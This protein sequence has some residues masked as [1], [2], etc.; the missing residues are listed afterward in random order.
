MQ[1]ARQFNLPAAYDAH[2]LALAERLEAELWTL[3]RKLFNAVHP[4]FQRINL[5][6]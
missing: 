1:L 3:D 2:Y 4:I 5:A 6:V